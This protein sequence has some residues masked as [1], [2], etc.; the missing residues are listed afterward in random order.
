MIANWLIRLTDLKVG[1]LDRNSSSPFAGSALFE[2]RLTSYSSWIRPR[3]WL[4]PIQVPVTGCTARLIWSSFPDCA[5]IS[6]MQC[7]RVASDLSPS[8]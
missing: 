2:R 8:Q 7:Q 1:A 5:L 6:S 3:S 4:I